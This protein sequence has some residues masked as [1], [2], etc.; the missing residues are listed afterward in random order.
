MS[1]KG[2]GND[3][4]HCYHF[5]EHGFKG[6]ALIATVSEY[7][8]LAQSQEIC[9]LA[10]NL[11][12]PNYISVLPTIRVSRRHRAS[13]AQFFRS[14]TTMT[15]NIVSRIPLGLTSSISRLS[16]PSSRRLA[17]QLQAQRQG[18]RPPKFPSRTFT[19][20]SPCES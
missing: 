20:T 5:I 1:G 9:C 7:P 19:T 8:L 10:V 12:L 3:T 17:A 4:D 13:F 14:Q 6:V 18:I 15:V 11:R 2:R 16:T